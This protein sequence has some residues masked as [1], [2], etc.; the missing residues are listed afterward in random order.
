M[1]NASN[2]EKDWNWISAHNTQGVEMKN[3]SDETSL[4]AVQGPKAIDVLQKL[5]TAD[6]SK[7]EYYSFIIDE[8]AGIKNVIISATGYTGA[9]GFEL[10]VPNQYAETLW[11]KIFEAGKEQ[12]IKPIGLGARDT[13]RLEM[14][15]VC[16]AMILTIVLLL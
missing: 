9:G 16:M 14:D 1:V 5:T 4:F 10:Y 12:H 15:I 7:I 3:I 11:K 8:I 6:L 2:I 13:L